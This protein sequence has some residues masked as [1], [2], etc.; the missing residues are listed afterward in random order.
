MGENAQQQGSRIVDCGCREGVAR[1]DGTDFGEGEYV[2]VRLG[3]ESQKKKGC[4][5]SLELA[6]STNLGRWRL[7]VC[8]Y[9][10]RTHGKRLVELY[11]DCTWGWHVAAGR[12]M[13]PGGT[14][15][16]AR[17]LLQYE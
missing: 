5:L 3:D 7:S 12:C 11:L 4:F 17:E 8:A 2:E 14:T 9:P 15:L 13:C 16:T 1:S 6:L 10:N